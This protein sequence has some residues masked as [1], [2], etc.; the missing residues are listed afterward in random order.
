MRSSIGPFLMVA[1]YLAGWIT[2]LFNK[3]SVSR[4]QILLLQKMLY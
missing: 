2:D 1:Q 4:F 3:P